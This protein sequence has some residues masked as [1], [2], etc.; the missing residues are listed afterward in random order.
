MD[1]RTCMPLRTG[2]DLAPELSRR[3]APQGPAKYATPDPESRR[4]HRCPLIFNQQPLRKPAPIF[5]NSATVSRLCACFTC[6]VCP[7]ACAD[8]VDSYR[9]AGRVPTRIAGAS[10]PPSIPHGMRA[11]CL[12]KRIP[13]S[14]S[15]RVRTVSIGSVFSLPRRFTETPARQIQRSACIY[16]RF[17]APLAIR[18]LR[19]L[20]RRSCLT[21][22]LR[23]CP[24]P[25]VTVLSDVQIESY[26]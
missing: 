5:N 13:V 2:T 6:G 23:S 8:A 14:L 24:L 15:H 22:A 11:R 17:R 18:S 9:C 3:V 1:I 25:S 19:H 7:I 16:W 26:S 20:A 21:E 10:A 4:R 12:V